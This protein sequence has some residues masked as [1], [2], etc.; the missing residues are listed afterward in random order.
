MHIIPPSGSGKQKLVLGRASL[1]FIDSGP[2][3]SFAIRDILSELSVGSCLLSYNRWTGWISIELCSSR[4][5][6]CSPRR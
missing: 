6:V 2:K 5:L 1:P 4:M 3:G